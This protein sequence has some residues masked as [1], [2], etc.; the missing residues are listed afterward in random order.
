V[1]CRDWW[2]CRFAA[3][4]GNTT[5][6]PAMKIFKPKFPEILVLD[7]YRCI[8]DAG[9][10]EKFPV[11]FVQPAKSNISAVALRR[12]LASANIPESD[13]VKKVINWIDNGAEIWVPGQIQGL[14]ALKKR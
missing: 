11:N 14:F 3:T 6:D 4:L 7:D 9:F 5:P 12:Q 2:K 1:A 8:S 10:W 13:Q